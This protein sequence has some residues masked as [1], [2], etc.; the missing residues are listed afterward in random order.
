MV[1]VR[2][3]SVTVK[4][5]LESKYAVISSVGFPCWPVLYSIVCR[6]CIASYENTQIIYSN[7]M[8]NTSM[9]GT[10]SLVYTA[11]DD[12]AGLYYTKRPTRKSNT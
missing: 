12:P 4:G 11:L 5:R 3:D 9:I 6:Q 7:T 2:F 8:V 10:Y 1:E